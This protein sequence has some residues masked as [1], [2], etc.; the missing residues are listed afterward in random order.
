MGVKSTETMWGTACGAFAAYK[1][2]PVQRELANSIRVFRKPWLRYTGQIAAFSFAYY[3][4]TQM[5]MRLFRLASKDN[6]GATHDIKVA[7][8]DVVS[9]FRLF[10]ESEHV[11]KSSQYENYANYLATYASDPLSKPELLDQ[12]MKNIKKNVDL[13]K[14]FRVKRSGA[15]L[16][17]I[18]YTFGKVHGLENIAFCD[19]ADI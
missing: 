14:V 9:R 4:G 6:V 3:V 12:M 2:G 19:E 15:D 8:A 17:D 16:D 11:G 7:Q 5:P 13:S 1:A 18:F 10:D